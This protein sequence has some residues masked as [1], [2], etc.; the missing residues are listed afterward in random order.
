[1]LS[2]SERVSDP[3]WGPAGAITEDALPRTAEIVIVG[4]GIMGLATAYHLARAGARP[5]VLEREGIGAGATGRNGGFLPVG[6]AEDYDSTIARLG[7]P[8]ARQLLGLTLDNRRLAERIL[9]DEGIACDFRP[10]GHLHLAVTAAEQRGNRLLAELLSEDGCATAHLDQQ[11]AQSLIDTPLGA[12]VAGGLF[13]RDI[14]LVHSGKLAAGLARAAQR[15]GATIARAEV[16]SLSGSGPGV[17][18]I[19]ER[20][21]ISADAAL[22]AVNAWTGDL[23]PA[24]RDLITPVRGQV[25]AFAPVAPVFRT[26]L[27]A[28]TTATEEYWQQLPDG[29]ILL[30]GCRGIRPDGDEAV[31]ARTTTADVQG[32][33]ER[34]LPGLF[35]RIGA[36]RVTHRWAGPMAFTADRLPI[37]ARWPE[38]PCW[39]IG[40]FSGNGMSLSLI[41]GQLMADALLDRPCDPRLGFFTPDRFAG[42]G[43]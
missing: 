20:G 10:V 25:L 12:Q 39:S 30:G 36:L 11:E 3:W 22:T 21:T 31:R 5:L 1:M 38:A 28:L 34:V 37:V 13:F 4:A 16:V 43:A 32:A 27:T 29:S 17:R 26:G 19:S 33:L 7:R 6:T 14:A 35:P 41:L 23:V 40:G 8:L 15:H 42:A 18:V 2:E 9:T 24:L